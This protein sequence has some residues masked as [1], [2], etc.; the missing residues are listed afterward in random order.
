MSRTSV[1]RDLR[2]RC[3]RSSRISGSRSRVINSKTC[4]PRLKNWKTT[5]TVTSPSQQ[6]STLWPNNEI[7][8]IIH[9]LIL[10]FGLFYNITNLNFKLIFFFRRI[11]SNK[12]FGK[13]SRARSFRARRARIRVFCNQCPPRSTSFIL[14]FGQ[15]IS[16][17]F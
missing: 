2:R 1:S 15:G 3:D 7:I 6:C 17:P 9:V 4:A 11:L 5:L 12:S 8:Y 16:F 14:L 10:K 13:G